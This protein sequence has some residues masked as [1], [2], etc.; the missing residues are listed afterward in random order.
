MRKLV[1]AMKEIPRET[2]IITGRVCCHSGA[3]WGGCGE[4]TPD[5]SA[6]RAIA[7]VEDQLQWLDN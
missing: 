3:E 4:G 6:E 5:Y 2:V 7:D 1:L